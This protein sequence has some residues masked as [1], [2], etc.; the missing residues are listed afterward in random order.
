MVRTDIRADAPVDH[1]AAAGRQHM[2]DREFAKIPG[3]LRSMKRLWPD[4]PGLQKRRDLEAD[5]F[6]VDL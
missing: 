2:V 4:L 6:A 3:E 5:L 1:P